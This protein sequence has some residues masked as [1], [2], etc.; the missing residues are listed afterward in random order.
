[1]ISYQQRRIDEL[2][3]MRKGLRAE[4]DADIAKVS[5]H[6]ERVEPSIF[7]QDL[8]HHVTPAAFNAEIW[9][10]LR[11]FLRKLASSLGDIGR[12]S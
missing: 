5:I 7:E 8:R 11:R 12:F 6:A 9:L 4:S 3:A 2:Y 10:T 1:M